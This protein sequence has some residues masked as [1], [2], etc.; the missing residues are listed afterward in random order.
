MKHAL[1]FLASLL[2][3]PLGL[4]FPQQLASDHSTE[5]N[6]VIL[7]S[8]DGARGDFVRDLDLPVI[9]SLAAQGAYTYQAQTILPSQTLPGHAS[10]LSGYTPQKHGIRV[11]EWKEGLRLQKDTIFDHISRAG[12]TAKLMAAKEKFET[13]RKEEAG[14]DMVILNDFTDVMTDTTI[15][16]ISD[17]DYDFLFVHFKAPDRAGHDHGAESREYREAIKEVDTAIG[18]IV[19]RL[20]ELGRFDSTTLIITADHGMRGKNHGG[21]TPEELTIPWIAVGP[22]IE[23]K[24]HMRMPVSVMDTTA[25]ALWLLGIP[26]PPDLDG[27]VPAGIEKTTSNASES[28]FEAL[29]S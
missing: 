12:K 28:F 10:M 26:L 8:M 9:H 23:N 24:F 16:T 11:N 2:V 20:R 14:V 13:F 18:K 4:S 21:P 27:R 6:R 25:V 3:L 17:T 29:R 19:D 1:A 5:K 7:I 15:A 22:R